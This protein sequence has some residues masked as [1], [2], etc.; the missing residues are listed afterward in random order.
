MEPN[1]IIALTIGGVVGIIAVTGLLITHVNKNRNSSISDKSNSNRDS[2]SDS[3][4]SYFGS[5]TINN[6]SFS[7]SDMAPFRDASITDRQ[8][9][10]SQP[11][12]AYTNNGNDEK[13]WITE[14]QKT[15]IH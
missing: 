5:N 1:Q 12:Y 2:D 10:S 11:R 8:S 3:D 13:Q 15:W 6:A 4:S 14:L 9:N 7:E